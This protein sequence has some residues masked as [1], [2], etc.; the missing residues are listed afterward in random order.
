MKVIPPLI[1]A[2]ALRPWVSSTLIASIFLAGSVFSSSAE[3]AKP[4]TG[5]GLSPSYL[6]CE[7]LID[8]L[9]MDEPA[10]RL[11][12]IVESGERA[13]R[14]TAYR[15]L[16][17]TNESSLKHDSGELWDSGKVASDD[18]IAVV[19]HG[20][21][22]ASHQRCFWKVKVWD[23]DDRGSLPGANPPCGPWVCYKR[24]IGRPIGSVATNSASA[25]FRRLPWMAQNGSGTQR[26]RRETFPNVNASFTP[27]SICP[28][29]PR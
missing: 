9:G 12:W 14:Q 23:R 29:M 5:K 4:Y 3:G 20:P 13:Q 17:S 24:K 25:T 10:P 1:M 19:Y 16:V 27:P 6:R 2:N 21:P 11:S 28:Q 26:I 7:Y 8:P 22:L 18:T 15:I